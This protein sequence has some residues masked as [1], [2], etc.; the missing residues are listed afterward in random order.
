MQSLAQPSHQRAARVQE[1]TTPAGLSVWLVEDYT[2][3]MIA[4]ECAWK[5]GAAQDPRDKAGLVTMM[6]G[7]LDEGAG[8]LD[9]SAFHRALDDRAI[10][11]SFS[12]TRDHLRGHLK[13][14]VQ[15]AQHAFDLLRLAVNEPRFDED[16]LER[17]RAQIIAS[18]KREAQDPDFLVGQLWREMTM[19][20]HPYGQPV[21][22]DVESI[23]R[24]SRADM[25][26]AHR[27]L[28]CRD[29]LVIAVVG[30]IDATTLAGMIDHSF[31]DLPAQA[32][33]RPVAD[34]ILPDQ[35]ACRVVD[36]DVPQSTLRFGRQGI[37]RKDPDFIAAMVVNHILGG[38]VFSARLFREVRE[39]RGLAYSVHSQLL[40][41][42]HAAFF[43]GG[44]STKNER[45]FESLEVIEAQIAD[46]AQQGPSAEELEKAKK[47]LIG[48][49][50]LR[51]DSSTKIANQL[52]GLQIEGFAKTYLDE[53]NSEIAAVSVEQAVRVAKRLFAGN[54]LIVAIAG[55]PEKV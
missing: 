1:I 13:T 15:S 34:V 29:H 19:P 16:A 12:A 38:G 4:L 35:P 9:A 33:L 31:A 41:Y 25:V 37:A 17:I 55:R 49:Y 27:A 47:Y 32:S 53:R 39:K 6:T 10:E 23:G 28:V 44:T 18:H 7:L 52:V 40:T 20:D 50:D 46:L 14:L 3:P 22:G 36:V 5:G 48:S 30:A 24:L 51:F 54:R 42:D 21:R 11:I 26:G 45:A 2:V 8:T 43:S